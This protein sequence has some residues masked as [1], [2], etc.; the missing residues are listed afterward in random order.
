MA[1][2]SWL[3]T[4][5]AYADEQASLPE[6][7]WQD[8]AWKRENRAGLG[9]GATAGG[10]DA[11][12]DSNYQK[13][14]IDPLFRAQYAWRPVRGLETGF[15]VNYWFTSYFD[16]TTWHFLMPGIHVRPYM[17]LNAARTVEL[18]LTVEA[19]LLF[20]FMTSKPGVWSGWGPS[21][22]PD[23][24]A[25]LSPRFGIQVGAVMGLANGHNPRIVPDSYIL[26]DVSMIYF[27]LWA[28]PVVRW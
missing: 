23:V 6:E 22:G 3:D 13:G 4:G 1:T 15:D 5:I 19:R 28:G 14:G 20:F 7:T 17:D 11:G 26:P 18:G 10:A 21:I 25:W 8:P 12:S 24:R 27:G 16:I 2:S 9:L